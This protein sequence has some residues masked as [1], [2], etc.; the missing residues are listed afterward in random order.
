M[1]K[2]DEKTL[3]ELGFRKAPRKGVAITTPDGVYFNLA[4]GGSTDFQLIVVGPMT[5]T[6][7]EYADMID[8][9]WLL[10]CEYLPPGGD[11]SPGKRQLLIERGIFSMVF[12]SYLTADRPA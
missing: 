4:E 6:P 10:S 8:D 11:V 5:K 1:M 3:L 9:Y 7:G 12:R 2:M